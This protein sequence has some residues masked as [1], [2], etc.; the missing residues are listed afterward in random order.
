MLLPCLSIAMPSFE[1]DM[2]VS[3]V[4]SLIFLLSAFGC[5]QKSPKRAETPPQASDAGGSS[6]SGKSP[7]TNPPVGEPAT[8][9]PQ[10]PAAEAL[11]AD[12]KTVT[13]ANKDAWVSKIPPEVVGLYAF[14]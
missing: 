9:S 4:L 3:P 1:V 13:I 10:E 6:S 7:G 11:S 8:T 5:V 14:E 12:A 2:S